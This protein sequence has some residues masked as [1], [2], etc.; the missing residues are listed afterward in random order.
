VTPKMHAPDA[1]RDG[2]VTYD[3]LRGPD[4]DAALWSPARLPLPTGGEHIP[5]DPNAE[6]AVGEG[7]VRVTI[8]RFSLSHDRFQSADSPKYLIFS[9]REFE[10]PPDRPATFAVDLAVENI[11]GDPADYRRGMAAFHVFDLVSQRVFAACGTSTRVLALHEQ[12]G[13]GGGGA[14]EPFYHVVESPYEDFDD[15]FTRLRAC[16]ITLDRSTSTAA[17]RVDGRTVYEAHGTLIPD[18]AR[19]GF[20]IWTMQ[21]IRDGRSRSLAGQ[22]LSARWRR[23]RVCGIHA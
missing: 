2:F 15:D 11:G 12:L 14:G 10:L 20:A 16:E 19:I 13:L 3:E 23:F 9:T 1:A 21:P 17:W 7:E 6:L 22:G 5:L 8:P 18:H 4:L